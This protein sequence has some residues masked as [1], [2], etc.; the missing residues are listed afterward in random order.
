MS[1]EFN[2][3]ETKGTTAIPFIYESFLYNFLAASAIAYAL[4]IPFENIL[5]QTK[6]LKP[7]PMRGEILQLPGDILLIDDSYNSNPAALESILKDISRLNAKRKVA[8]LGD[9]LELGNTQISYHQKAG[10]QVQHNAWDMLITVGPISLHMAEGALQAG[11]NQAQIVSFENS[12]KAAD[13]V[14][15]FLEPGDVVLVKGSRGIKMDKIVAK[16]KQGG[17]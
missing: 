1:F 7:F 2:Y 10:K 11:M 4:S 17:I 13:Q 5:E 14:A 8:I 3:G 12:D 6:T 9:M 16:L 15:S